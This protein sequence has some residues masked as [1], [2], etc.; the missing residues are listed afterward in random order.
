MPRPTARS[1]GPVGCRRRRAPQVLATC[2]AALALSAGAAAMAPPRGQV[3]QGRLAGRPEADGVS[4]FLGLPFA[5]PPVGDRR[6]RP[7]APALSWQGVR[8]ADRYGASCPQAVSP[9]G[10]GPWTSE[11]V[12]QPPV[13]EDCLFLNVWAKTPQARKRPVLVWIHGGAFLSGSGSVPIYDGARL[14]A[15]DVVVVTINY[16]LGA[17]GFLA[18]PDLTA[19]SGASGDYGLMDQIAALKWVRR[20]IAAFGGDPHRVTI[21]G[22]SAGALSVLALMEAPQARGLFARA[23]AESGAGLALPQP[24]LPAAE[25]QGRAFAAAKGARTIAE[26]RAMPVDQLLAPTRALAAAGVP[27]LQF[28]PIRDGRGLPRRPGRLADVPILTGLTL[29]EGSGFNLAYGR[30]TAAGFQVQVRTQY[31]PAGEEVLRLYPGATDVEARQSALDLARDRGVFATLLWLGHRAVQ[32]R[33]PAYAY[34]YDHAEPGPD[35]TRFGAFHSSEIPYVFR[36]LDAAAER[37]FTDRDRALSELM[38]SYWVNFIRTGDPNGGSLP[39]WAPYVPGGR[40]IMR[41]GDQTGAHEL[42]AARFE[43]LRAHSSRGG[44]VSLF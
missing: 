21:A 30:A 23:I 32:A 39:A 3:A 22:Q 26:L 18:H 24:A 12:V 14:A 2:L 15:N 5:A 25:I 42:D 44:L 6:W 33:A 19:E 11:Y 17:L 7:P 4:A 35:A 9:N 8:S 16:R 13:A 34:L 10:F 38:S 1:S 27:G 31:G 29:D 43:V 41:L 40:A 20:N 36:T 28:L 37:P